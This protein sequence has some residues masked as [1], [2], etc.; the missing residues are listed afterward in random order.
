MAPKKLLTAKDLAA[1][2]GLSVETVW[3]YTREGQIPHIEVGARQ[4]RYVEADV[5]T[6][7]NKGQ[8]SSQ[9]QEEQADY[10]VDRKLTYEDYAKVPSE[11]GSTLQ[12][13]DGYLVRDPSPTFI[14]QRVSGKLES[15]LRDF[16]RVFDPQGEIFDAPLD[17]IL[18]KHTVLQ[19]DLLY[20]PSS[21]PA[22]RDPVDSLPELVVEIT[23]P[24][25]AQTDR[26]RKFGSYLK[27]GI[28]HYW[29]VD[30]SECTIQCYQLK[31]GH[32][33]M[34][35]VFGNG[36]FSHPAFPGLEFEVRALF[37]PS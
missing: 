13:I 1:V 4:Y 6:A 12:L 15:I 24:S 18:D 36:T 28:P 14:H 5:L 20:L 29:V 9:V 33:S 16:F 17:V 19:P 35:A 11:A 8:G 2:L 10:V 37:T 26:V 27:A 32:Y 21:R 30:P 31:D 22:K 3:R 7:L 23:S 25:T 34:V